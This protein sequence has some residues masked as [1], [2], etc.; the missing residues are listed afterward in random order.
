MSP[1]NE[2]DEAEIRLEMRN[3]YKELG[4]TESLVVLLEILKSAEILMEVIA[5]ERREENKEC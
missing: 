1:F 3:I 4:F 5:E 2:L